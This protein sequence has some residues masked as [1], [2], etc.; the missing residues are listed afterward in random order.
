MQNVS[1]KRVFLVG[2]V[3]G[4]NARFGIVR[5]GKF[6]HRMRTR[7]TADMSDQLTQVMGDIVKIAGVVPVRAVLAVA[8]QIANDGS[9]G[10]SYGALPA[11]RPDQ[12]SEI[13]GFPVHTVNDAVAAAH[14]T[15]GV[16]AEDVELLHGPSPVRAD[17][18]LVVTIGT[19]VGEAEV[20]RTNGKARILPATGGAMRFSPVDAQG[21]ALQRYFWSHGTPYL[22]YGHLLGG[23]RG[24]PNLFAYVSEEIPPSQAVKKTLNSTPAD[25]WSRVVVTNALAG[26]DPACVKTIELWGSILGQFLGS[27][28]G[29]TQTRHVYLTG[30]IMESEELARH[31]VT[32]TPFREMFSDQGPLTEGIRGCG[33]SRLRFDDAGLRGAAVLAKK[34]RL[35]GRVSAQYDIPDWA[36]LP[37]RVPDANGL[38]TSGQDLVL[39]LGNV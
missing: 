37:G 6:I 35:F 25:E 26:S 11:F 36:E 23:R 3:G 17:R 24:I 19:S 14:V 9:F 33:V 28:A 4:T 10:L 38:V 21:Q 39:K 27:R 2:D 8:G 1:D 13:L 31:V 18:Q 20:I 7:T 30:G 12:T 5:G 34:D 22:H 15:P 16:A 32:K 29:V